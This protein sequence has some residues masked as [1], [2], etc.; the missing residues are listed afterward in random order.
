ML[1]VLHIDTMRN[2][3]G[4]ERQAYYL[5]KGLRGRGCRV[6]FACQ[7]DSELAK[8]LKSAGV[9]VYPTIFRCEADFTA[10]WRV[11]GLIRR[12]NFQILHMHD[13]HAHWLGGCAARLAGRPVCIVSR[14]VDFSIRRHGF[15]LSI[16]KYRHFADAYAAVSEAVKSA[17]VRDGVPAEMIHVIHSGVRMPPSDEPGERDK[18]NRMLGTNGTT[19]IV[20]SIGSLVGHK[21]HRYLVE[22]APEIL[23]AMP[24][25][26][27][28]VLGEG[29]LRRDLE[30]RIREKGLS[31]R[32]FLPG[33]DPSASRLLSAFDVFVM[34]SVMEGLGTSML[35]AMAAGVPVVAAH[36]GGI[37][38]AVADLRTGLLAKP[39]D[40]HSL[41]AAVQKILRD[42]ELAQDLARRAREEVVTRFTVSHMVGRTMSLY[43]KFLSGRQ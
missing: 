28:V 21:G 23:R 38:E 2:W 24:D 43:R 33:H 8:K 27:F 26:R 34:P 35:D 7:P 9:A 22:A 17:L 39:G 19:R 11:A 4:G 20:G 37:P 15:G 32:F 5:A 14:R 36:A 13:S 12:Y 16:I 41:A 29:R 25:V 10:A 40:S 3:R 18:L 6:G 31:G 30:T 42:R 1:G